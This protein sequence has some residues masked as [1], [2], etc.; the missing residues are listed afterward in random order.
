MVGRICITPSIMLSEVPVPAYTIRL[1]SECQI[2]KL[3]RRHLRHSSPKQTECYIHL[4]ILRFLPCRLS[5]HPMPLKP[6]P[7]LNQ[8]IRTTPF[9]I[10]LTLLLAFAIGIQDV[11]TWPSFR[12]FASSQTGNT[13][14]IAV[15]A[16]SLSPQAILPP[17]MPG[18][19]LGMFVAGAMLQGQA[20][21]I[22]GC[23]RRRWWLLVSNALQ[24]ALVFAAVALQISFPVESS[25]SA[26]LGSVALLA[27]SSGSQVG[28][29]RGL[30]I[31]EITTTMATAAYV[32]LVVDKP[33]LG[34]F[35]GN[36]ARNR[37]VGFL[38]ALILESFVG[39]VVEK[40]APTGMALVVSGAVKATVT[41]LILLVEEGGE[42][43][44]SGDVNLER[45]LRKKQTGTI[46]IVR[47][48]LESHV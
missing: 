8:D 11:T 22:M 12:V 9:L 7:Y 18:L 45:Y 36:V 38:L 5:P 25:T 14:I 48:K 29:A 46:I 34:R 23:A 13:V 2:G 1:Y 16:F 6:K 26:A 30:G 33:M 10:A 44:V 43:A 42:T 28:M 27:F 4:S 21:N 31:R 19:S 40:F 24:T 15:A 20:G 3:K 35:A 17:A 32:D 39:A 47:D 41:V 37:R